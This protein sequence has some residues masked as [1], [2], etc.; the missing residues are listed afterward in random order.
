[1]T[2]VLIG[3]LWTALFMVAWATR[4]RTAAAADATHAPAPTAGV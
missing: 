2:S 4:D 1:V 3:V